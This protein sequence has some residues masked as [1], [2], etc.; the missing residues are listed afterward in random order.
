MPWIIGI[1][2]VIAAIDYAFKHP[3]WWLIALV[4]IGL[5]ITRMVWEITEPS[6]KERQRLREI[7]WN[8]QQ[9]EERKQ[10]E[11]IEAQERLDKS[12]LPNADTFRQLF[13]QMYFQTVEKLR[14]QPI[15]PPL[16]KVLF[17]ATQ[18]R[19]AKEFPGTIEKHGIML[20]TAADPHRAFE[21]FTHVHLHSI[22]NFTQQ[23]PQQLIA[24]PQTETP[25]IQSIDVEKLLI[26]E[27]D[28]FTSDAIREA[29][30]S[31]RTPFDQNAQELTALGLMKGGTHPELPEQPDI[32]DLDKGDYRA[33]MRM[34][35][36]TAEAIHDALQPVQAQLQGTSFFKTANDLIPKRL[37]KQ[38]FSIPPETWFSSTWVC[39]PQGRGKTNLLHNI[40]QQHRKHGTV[41]LMDAKGELI[42]PYRNDAIIIEPSLT[43]PPQINP[44]DIGSSIHAVELLE[45]LFSSLLEAKMTPKQSTLFAG[46]LTLLT[47]VPNATVETFRQILTTGWKPYERY[48][49]ALAPRDRD[50]FTAGAFDSKA[51]TTTKEEVLWRLQLLLRNPYMAAMLEVPR[52][53]LN[54]K[55]LMDSGKV[56][57][58]ENN[59]DILGDVGA[60]F[61]GRFVI[62]LV[63]NAVRARANSSTQKKPVFFFIDE[64]QTVISRDD[65]I[66]KLIQQ[67]R[68]QNVAL[69]FAHQELQQMKTDDVKGA[70]ANCAIRFAAPDGEIS[71][72]APRFRTTPEFLS[73]LPPYH[74]AACVRGKET[75][76]V[77]VP[78]LQLPQTSRTISEPIRQ[79]A[80]PNFPMDSGPE[81]I[82]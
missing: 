39:A 82:G 34:W 27:K 42:A 37:L 12:G 54:I 81:E 8:K 43:N 73:E 28:E 26:T 24:Q 32:I 69:I 45:Y 15:V 71:V 2:V 49:N 30:A 19:Y 21:L 18:K 50:F 60:E 46:V 1:V 78:L 16:L 3:I 55:E 6:R 5:I 64:A 61:F 41:I 10:R 48:V 22:L 68:S 35:H 20:K 56:I 7:E 79:I 29:F 44:L 76:A 63:W 66:P 4:V 13:E 14:K 74:F 47:T 57:I 67:C 9:E 31:M 53:T 58:V 62:A 23:A 51:Y 17:D 11:V 70:L 72:L 59:P 38:P 36:K 75:V 33:A 40:V 80:S 77:T 25:F 65:N 52:T